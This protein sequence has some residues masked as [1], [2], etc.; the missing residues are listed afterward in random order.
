[1]R[2]S[3]DP[4]HSFFRTWTRKEAVIKLVGLGLATSLQELDTTP[5]DHSIIL[6]PA[7]K[8]QENGCWLED[9]AIDLDH[10]AAVASGEKP[11]RVH[12]FRGE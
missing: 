10:V 8:F 7:W 2:N 5:Q 1:M 3:D 4:L 9:L 11:H 12:L 6:P